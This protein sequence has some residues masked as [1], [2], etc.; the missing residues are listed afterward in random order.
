MRRVLLPAAL[1]VAFVLPLLALAGGGAAQ[2]P[3][4]RLLIDIQDDGSEVLT[5]TF[6]GLSTSTE[7]RGICLPA[8]AELVSLV[9]GDGALP[10]SASEEDGRVSMTFRPRTP[11]VTAT[12]TRPMTEE[13]AAPLH[14][15]SANFCTTAGSSVE[16][17]ARAAPRYE[18]FFA[19]A[20]GVVA[21]GEARWVSDGP[22][23]VTYAFEAPL[24]P[25]SG[26]ARVEEG[27]FRMFVPQARA[28]QAAE[29]ARVAAPAFERALDA[30]GIALPWEPLRVHYAAPGEFSW[31]AGHYG[32]DGIIAVKPGTLAPDVREGYPYVA[33]KVVVH[34]AFHA[35]SAP[36]GKGAVEDVIAWW[37]E[38]TARFAEREVDRE[39]PEGAKHCE[40]EGV[41]IQCWFFDDRISEAEL[42]AA[43]APDFSFQRRWEP[44]LPQT[45]ETRR[46]YYAYSEFLVAN[47]VAREG[48]TTY[49]QVWDALAA[50]F[51]DAS[52]C[53]CGDGWL[54]ELLLRHAGDDVA[55][56]DLYQ[57]WS[58]LRAS[59]PVA[60]DARVAG[61]VRAPQDIE[62]PPLFGLPI[63]AAWTMASLVAVALCAAVFRVSRRAR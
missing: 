49:A 59:D 57:P 8:R 14:K 37:L 51:D 26:L 17:V 48:N 10:H 53:P 25:S 56:D 41:R 40:T 43:Y 1:V 31:E 3:S 16:V 24:D 23:Y 62:A 28:L 22:N 47:Y 61:F 32:G 12:M 38:G 6:S 13:G 35:A 18:L 45:E 52:R 63:P 11:D 60:F 2:S 27:P 50:A 19:S 58:K 30:A 7:Y 9:D 4:A 21:N 29:V 42:E 44:S 54:E 55:A 46:F 15:A 39:L 36:Y 5:L 34:E 33:A 20:P